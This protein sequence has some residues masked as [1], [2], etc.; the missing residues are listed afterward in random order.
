VSP[1]LSMAAH[2]GDPKLYERF[3]AEARKANQKNDKPDRERFLNALSGFR[4][5]ALV[6]RTRQMVLEDE[7]PAFETSRLL[8][9]GDDTQAERDRRWAFLVEH[10]AQIV[11][12]LPREQ[13]ARLVSLGGDC[14]AA[15]LQRAEAFFGERT[16]KEL[17]GPRTYKSFVEGQRLC[18]AR[19]A[20]DTDSFV[21][22][23]RDH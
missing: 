10:Y 9:V 8:S 20:K 14:T 1:V 17:S 18:I 4:A 5:P 12:R 23:L 19:R 7:F 2:A 11:A 3:L 13:R 21:Q 15:G 16:P 22:F 6:A